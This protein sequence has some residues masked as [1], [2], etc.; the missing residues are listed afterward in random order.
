MKL[1]SVLTKF[2]NAVHHMECSWSPRRQSEWFVGHYLREWGA[3][4]ICLQE[5][6]VSQ[7]DQRLWSTFGWGAAR[8]S[9]SIEASGRS[10]GVLLAWNEGRFELLSSW[11]ERHLKAARLAV[12]ADGS[13]LTVT[14]A[15][16][17]SVTQRRGELSEDISQLCLLFIDVPILIGGD[18]N[19]TIAPKDRPNGL[20]GCDPGS[21][22]LRDVL[23]QC[24]LQ[25]MGPTDWSFT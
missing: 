11:K 15:Y 24:G 17:P 2:P 3:D 22:Q 23:N 13:Q 7:A 21:A 6:I 19:V 20:G 16:G 8:A 1:S 25:E 5:T 9:T 18:L 4:I 10:G 12:R 14:S